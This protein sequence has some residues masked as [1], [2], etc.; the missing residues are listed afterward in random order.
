MLTYCFKW[1]ISKLEQFHADPMQIPL[2]WMASI[3]E[4]E[5]LKNNGA[6]LTNE[7]TIFSTSMCYSIPLTNSIK[8]YNKC[9]LQIIVHDR[10]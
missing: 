3:F 1:R 8:K 4:K 2:V 6:T 7:W 5:N 9:L 10:K